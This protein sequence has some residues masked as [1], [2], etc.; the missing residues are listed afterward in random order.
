[1]AQ[2]G[3][4]QEGGASA[5]EIVKNTADTIMALSQA[6]ADNNRADISQALQKVGQEFMAIMSEFVAGGQ[7]GGGRA[8]PV[9]ERGQGTPVGPQGVM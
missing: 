2:M 8:A 5:E 9:A 4:E 6:A 7:Q 1:M 3:M